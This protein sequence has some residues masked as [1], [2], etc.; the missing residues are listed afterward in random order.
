MVYHPFDR[1]LV[2]RIEEEPAVPR[3]PYPSDLTD[4]QWAILEPL[5][6]PAKAAGRPRTTDLR[7][8][9]DAILYLVRSGCAWRMLPHDFPPHGTVWFYYWTWRE[10]G[11]LTRIHD[12]L[13]TQVRVADGRDPDPSAGCLDSQTVKT[14]EGGGRWGTTP[15]RRPR[16]AS[17][18]SSSTP[19]A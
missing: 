3:K 1:R 10:N 6:P 11:L 14:A 2:A 15:A 18:T 8:V 12:A 5:L 4:A 13:R 16:A 7:A 17:A 19:W 9:V